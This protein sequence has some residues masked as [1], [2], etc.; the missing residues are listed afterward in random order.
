MIRNILSGAFSFLTSVALFS[1]F[2]CLKLFSDVFIQAFSYILYKIIPF[3]QVP[4]SPTKSQK[5]SLLKYKSLYAHGTQPLSLNKLQI[6]P[7]NC[8]NELQNQ[9][10]Y[11]KC[12]KVATEKIN[13]KIQ[14]FPGIFFQFSRPLIP[15]LFQ[16]FSKNISK[17]QDFPGLLLW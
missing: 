10:Q 1:H 17:S 13:L 5:S 12:D 9:Y 2:F 11:R 15:G 16:D 8:L 3:C 14:D 6:V 7:W 4:V